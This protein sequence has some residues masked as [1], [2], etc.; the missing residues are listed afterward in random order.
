MEFDQGVQIELPDICSRNLLRHGVSLIYKNSSHWDVLAEL[1]DPSS[2]E[3][4]VGVVTLKDLYGA[5]LG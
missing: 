4:F 3:S 2:T 5:L 1:M